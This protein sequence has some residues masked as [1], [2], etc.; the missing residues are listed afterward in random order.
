MS[1]S[2]LLEFAGG[3]FN[4]SHPVDLP[5]GKLLEQ[6]YNCIP[7]RSL[8]LPGLMV[9]EPAPRVRDERIPSAFLFD[10]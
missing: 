8:R 10:G 6:F 4:Q 3:A 1:S 9:C 5:N 7:R 2:S